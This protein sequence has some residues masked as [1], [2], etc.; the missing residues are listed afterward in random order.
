MRG[1]SQPGNCCRWCRSRYAARWSG[2]LADRKQLRRCHRCLFFAWNG[3]APAGEDGA[4]VDP[5]GLTGGL[6]RCRL[7]RCGSSP[8]GR[9]ETHGGVLARLAHGVVAAAADTGLG[10]P[11]AC[12]AGGPHA[13]SSVHPRRVCSTRT[14]RSEHGHH[15]RRRCR[16]PSR[17]HSKRSATT[18]LARATLGPLEN[19]RGRL[20]KTRNSPAPS[21]MPDSPRCPL[22]EKELSPPSGFRRCCA[23]SSREPGIQWRQWS[24]RRPTRWRRH[25]PHQQAIRSSDD[26]IGS[27]RVLGTGLRCS[28]VRRPADR[29]HHPG[30]TRSVARWPAVDRE[31]ELHI[32]GGAGCARIH[33][34]QQVRR[35]LSGAATTAVA[36]RSIL[37]RR[38]ASRGRKNSSV[39]S[40]PTCSHTVVP[41]PTSPPTERS[42]CPAT[43]SWR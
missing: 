37:P 2:H 7:R 19:G 1:R 31:R 18:S 41:A 29:V 42:P 3:I 22:P 11:E 17:K 30:G 16:A 27:G 43:P 34:E 23:G 5:L 36:Q 13:P 15:R 12:A 10:S 14:Y 40:T 24:N 38:S 21:S 25:H 9:E 26:V 28:A 35:G 8:A 33:A 4:R 20:R 6:A 39:P 32:A